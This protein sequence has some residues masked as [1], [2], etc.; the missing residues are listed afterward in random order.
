MKKL[1]AVLAAAFIFFEGCE[2]PPSPMTET[3]EPQLVDWSVYAQVPVKNFE[4]L[5]FVSV[6]A[7]LKASRT[8][9][10]KTV[11]SG[12]D[13]TYYKIITEAKKLNADAVINIVIDTEETVTSVDRKQVKTITGA[14][15]EEIYSLQV[16][17]T[18]TGL[19]I[20][21]TD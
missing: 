17:K 8:S 5:G 18:A 1:Y 19:A 14:R 15:Y 21:Y 20:K 3:Y 16:K 7:F 9:G 12:D 10:E 13:I 6:T 2:T 4:P 11:W